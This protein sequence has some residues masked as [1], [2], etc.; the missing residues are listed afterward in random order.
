MA[1]DAPARAPKSLLKR[2]AGLA[3]VVLFLARKSAPFAAQDRNGL[4][5]FLLPGDAGIFSR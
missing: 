4:S 3:S 1:P 5:G 2:A